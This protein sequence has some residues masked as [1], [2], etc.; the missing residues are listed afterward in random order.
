MAVKLGIVAGNEAGSIQMKAVEYGTL[1]RG[2]SFLYPQVYSVVR[3]RE[4]DKLCESKSPAQ[5]L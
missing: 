5:Q 3:S 1:V 2:Y 4:H